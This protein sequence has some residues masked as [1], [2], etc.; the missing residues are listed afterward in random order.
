MAEWSISD[1]LCVLGLACFWSEIR[2][3]M[4]LVGRDDRRACLASLP[5]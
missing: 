2:I 3:A 5:G 1:S 4:R